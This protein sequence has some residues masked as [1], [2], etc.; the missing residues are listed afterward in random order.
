MARQ[1][2][3]HQQQ[4]AI[5]GLTPGL[6][7]VLFHGYQGT[8]DPLLI[9]DVDGLENGDYLPRRD[10]S[11]AAGARRGRTVDRERRVGDHIPGP[12]EL[13]GQAR[14]SGTRERTSAAGTGARAGEA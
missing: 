6:I 2:R 9:F 5:G 1:T 7:D 12:Q 11:A 3:R 14:T 8:V 4:A 10:S 13:R